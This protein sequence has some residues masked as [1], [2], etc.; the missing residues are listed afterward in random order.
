[1]QIESDDLTVD[2][3]LFKSFDS[4]MRS[5]L[6]PHWHKIGPKT[7]Q[8]VSDMA[9]LRQLLTLLLATDCV[10]FNQYLETVVSSSGGGT[11]AL[12]AAKAH[13]SPWLF[14]PAAETLMVTARKRVYLKE[15]EV[16]KVAAAD[17]HLQTQDDEEAAYWKEFEPSAEEEQE[18]LAM[19]DA[20]E[21]ETPQ[22]LPIKTK[23]WW[24]D[25]HIKPV[26][27]EQP[28]WQLLSEVLDEV[29]Q[30]LHMNPSRPGS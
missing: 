17:D 7:R 11:N 14:L 26:L 20:F 13:P 1:M 21:G 28:K 2:N 4:L 6:D 25:L 8:L 27:E 16:L 12:G 10:G 30:D 15:S 22:T 9:T 29:E 19:M 24:E 23:P 3:A 5:Q 18:A